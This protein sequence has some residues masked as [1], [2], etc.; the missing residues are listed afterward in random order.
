MRMRREG[1]L[2]LTIRGEIVVAQGL[3]LVLLLLSLILFSIII[4]FFSFPFS[5]LFFLSFLMFFISRERGSEGNEERTRGTE[6][7][8]LGYASHSC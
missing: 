1:A 6:V 2:E 3:D 5:L 7:L 4:F 8:V